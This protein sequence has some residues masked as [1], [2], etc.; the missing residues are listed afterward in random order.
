[1]H[2]YLLL[3][4]EKPGSFAA[5]GPAE[6]AEIVQRYQQWAANLAQ[7]GQ[8]SGGEKLTDSGGRQLHWR[9]GQTLAT[10]G[11]YA[12]AHDVIGGY[13]VIQAADD[14]AA[15]A[16]AASC[17]HLGPDRWIEIRRIEPIPA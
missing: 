14:A 12:E 17:P 8:L 9:A 13:F 5:A 7:Q 2:A 10:D 6:M 16:L 3:L 1:M 11:P 15:E 4:H